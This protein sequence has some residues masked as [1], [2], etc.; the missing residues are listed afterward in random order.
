V[1]WVGQVERRSVTAVAPPRARFRLNVGGRGERR[2]GGV[3]GA[4]VGLPALGRRE[5]MLG[6]VMA[7]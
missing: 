3:R 6:T 4:S 5:G 1:D 7:I 2:G